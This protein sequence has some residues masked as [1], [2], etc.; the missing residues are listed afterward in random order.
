M[1]AWVMVNGTWYKIRRALQVLK[2]VEA[3]EALTALI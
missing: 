1:G 2:S 3:D